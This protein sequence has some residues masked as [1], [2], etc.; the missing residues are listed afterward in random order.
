LYDIKLVFPAL[1]LYDFF[2]ALLIVRHF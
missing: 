1:F 2:S